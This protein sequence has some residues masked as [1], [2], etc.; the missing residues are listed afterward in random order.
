MAYTL[1]QGL[2]MDGIS[3]YWV[4]QVIPVAGAFADTVV[5]FGFTSHGLLMKNMTGNTLEYSVDGTTKHGEITAN[6]VHGFDF[7]RIPRI[8]LRSTA[9]AT[10]QITVW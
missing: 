3:G 2:N 7:R 6:E 5:N 10:V 8:W 1:E 9:G 4:S